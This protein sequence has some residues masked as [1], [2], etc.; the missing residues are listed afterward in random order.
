[1]IIFCFEWC[2]PF[3]LG[4]NSRKFSEVTLRI[5]DGTHAQFKS[6]KRRESRAK[7]IANCISKG[8]LGENSSCFGLKMGY[9]CAVVGCII[10]NSKGARYQWFSGPRQ[11]EALR[12]WWKLCGHDKFDYTIASKVGIL[13][14]ILT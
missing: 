2:L 6:D 11:E 3:V 5:Q 12:L 7:N 1:M 14:V 10:C 13:S 8:K 4:I 9:I